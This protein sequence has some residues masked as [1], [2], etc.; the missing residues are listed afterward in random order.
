MARTAFTIAALW[1]AVCAA[2]AWTPATASAAR[3]VLGIG[4][5]KPEMFGDPRWERLGI[6]HVRYIAPWDVLHD[7]VHLERLDRWM[8]AARHARAKVLLGFAH[9]LRSERL[10]KTLPSTRRFRREFLR[11]RARYPF[12]RSFIVWSEANHPGALTWK[13]P[14][15]AARFFDAVAG[16]CRG[17]R[18]VAADVLDDGGMVSWVRRFQRHARHRPRIWGVHNYGDANGFRTQGTRRLLAMTRGRIWFTETGGLVLRRTY[19]GGRVVDTY[20]YSKRHAARATRHILRLSCLSRRIR[21][22]YLYH[23]QAPPTVTNWDSALL[24]SRGA[25]RPAYRTLRRWMRGNRCR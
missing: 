22:V 25:V 20:R 21:R 18:V 1:V 14:R 2:M 19:R 24:G 10:A 5:Q 6:R 13:R 16:S 12:V 11:I 8:A 7:P 23:W 3:P 9:S 17:C 15:R 4:E